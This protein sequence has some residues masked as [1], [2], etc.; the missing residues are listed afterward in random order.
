[1]DD[2]ERITK[3]RNRVFETA[4]GM[5]VGKN[6]PHAMKTKADSVYRIT[7]MNQLKDIL[8]CGYVRPH[9]GKLKGGHENEIFWSKGSDKQFYYDTSRVVIEAPANN[10]KD[11]QIGAIPIED[12]SGI[13]QFNQEKNAFENRIDF[14]KRVYEEVHGEIEHKTK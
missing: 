5:A 13:W 1:M 3:S 12:L 9:E 2:N 4:N 8:A 11:N 7:G 6:I 14:Y 10:V